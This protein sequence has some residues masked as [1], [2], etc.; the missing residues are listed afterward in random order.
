MSRS[1][2]PKL[3][4]E[5]DLFNGAE[6]KWT[7]YKG[8]VPQG[9]MLGPILFVMYID[10]LPLDMHNKTLIYADDT[11]IYRPAMPRIISNAFTSERLASS[12][13]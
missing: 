6:S 9:S 3:H 12:C 2:S 5:G 13:R 11:K 8:G 1:F 4:A 10:D 7:I